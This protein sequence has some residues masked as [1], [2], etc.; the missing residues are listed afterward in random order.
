MRVRDNRVPL[1]EEDLEAALRQLEL[2]SS[3]ENV[4][5]CGEHTII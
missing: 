1:S 3:S 2:G 5:M 4:I